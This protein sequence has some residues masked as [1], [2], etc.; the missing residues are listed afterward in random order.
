MLYHDTSAVGVCAD[1]FK[2]GY[3]GGKSFR[4]DDPRPLRRGKTAPRR[5]G[6]ERFC[7]STASSAVQ[8]GGCYNYNRTAN[9]RVYYDTCQQD[10]TGYSKTHQKGNFC[11]KRRKGGLRPRRGQQRFR[12]PSGSQENS[13]GKE[14]GESGR[15]SRK[16]SAQ[17]RRT[18]G[19]CQGKGK[20]F[21]C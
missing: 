13:R 7:G 14:S 16:G 19:G 18:H 3:A 17:R 8:K 15:K 1:N 12:S 21:Q 6:H 4:G 5:R 20:E 2:R 11:C 10:R 9:V